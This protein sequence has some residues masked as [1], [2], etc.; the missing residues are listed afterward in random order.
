[1]KKKKK[2]LITFKE[3]NSLK[4]EMIK[5]VLGTEIEF[6][7]RSFC[8]LIYILHAKKHPMNIHGDILKCFE[9]MYK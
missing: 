1:M 7:K 6:V 4:I 2:S 5:V 8:I 9:I 3:E